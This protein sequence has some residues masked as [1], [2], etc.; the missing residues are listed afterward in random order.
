MMLTVLAVGLSARAQTTS[1][2]A[3]PKEATEKLIKIE[4]TGLGG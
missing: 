4:T 1:Q 3:T 2:P